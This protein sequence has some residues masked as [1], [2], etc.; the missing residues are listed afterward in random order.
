MSFLNVEG[1][2][3]EDSSSPATTLYPGMAENIVKFS[4]EGGRECT[5]Y[6]D[7][8]VNTTKVYCTDTGARLIK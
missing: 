3:L 1:N 7:Q 5:G 4:Q 8:R 6:Y 2:L